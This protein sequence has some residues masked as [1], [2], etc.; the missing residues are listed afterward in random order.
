MNTPRLQILISTFAADGLHRVA[1]MNLPELD[2]IGYIVSCQDPERTVSAP[3]AIL[4]PRR[5]LRL[6]MHSDRGLGLNRSHALG[7][8]EAEFVL[9][10]DDD[11]Q[12]SADG[13]ARALQAMEEHPDTDI[14]AFRYS[15]ADNKLYPPDMHDLSKPFKGYNFTSFELAFRLKAIRDRKLDFSPLTGVGAPY[16]TAAEESIFAERCLQQGLRG[17]FIPLTIVCH[18]GLTTGYRLASSAGFV[19]STAAYIYVKYGIVSGVARCLLLAARV[20]L[21]YP[22]ALVYALQGMAYAVKHRREL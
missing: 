18:P 9:L 11:L 21:P 17:L 14:F 8:A 1:A 6:Y 10:A 20:P 15:G 13:L 12:Y 19:R 3:A 7:H 4:Q 22:R 5:D 16:L 2:G